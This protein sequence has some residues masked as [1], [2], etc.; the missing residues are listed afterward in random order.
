LARAVMGNH[1]RAIHARDRR[2]VDDHPA[3]LL[4]H[5][6]LAGPLTAKEHAVEVDADHG[7]LAGDRDV[8]GLGAERSTGVVDHDV[9]PAPLG[10]RALDDAFDLVLLPNVDGNGK[11]AAAE[12]GDLL[13]DGLEMLELARAQR[14]VRTRARE[15][16]RNR[17]ADAGAAA[18]DDGGLAFERERGFGHGGDDTPAARPRLRAR[19]G[20]RL[21]DLRLALRHLALDFFP[22]AHL[23]ERGAVV[24]GALLQL[25][26]QAA[27]LRQALARRFRG[28]PYVVVTGLLRLDPRLL[29]VCDE[30]YDAI[31]LTVE[32]RVPVVGRVEMRARRAEDRVE[33][34]RERVDLLQ[35]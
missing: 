9:E 27:G 33:V 22:H 30:Q 12:V 6:L 17:L 3:R 1:R 5:H 16:D 14:D 29:D 20:L 13:R 2:D 4:R 7:V 23:R 25:V 15:L 34:L 21:G 11:R 32:I 24:V 31:D 8:L 35:V 26:H 28:A 19:A 18:R 10:H